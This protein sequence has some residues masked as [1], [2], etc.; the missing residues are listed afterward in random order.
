MTDVKYEIDELSKEDTQVVFVTDE[1]RFLSI[2]QQARQEQ[3]IVVS[4]ELYTLYLYVYKRSPVN[5][6][7]IVL[8]DQ[9]QKQLQNGLEVKYERYAKFYVNN[10]LVTSEYVDSQRVLNAARQAMST[11]NTRC[12]CDTFQELRQVLAQLAREKYQL[13]NKVV[14]PQGARLPGAQNDARMLKISIDM[15]LFVLVLNQL[16]GDVQNYYS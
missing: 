12:C 1:K 15:Q 5:C 6:N 16:P 9:E 13:D 8:H 11:P 14:L 7:L 2:C 10:V 3:F 4:F